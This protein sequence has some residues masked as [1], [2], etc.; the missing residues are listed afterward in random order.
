MSLLEATARARGIATG[1]V[2]QNTVEIADL[3]RA[4]IVRDG[5]KLPV[6]FSK[7]FFEGDLSQNIQL[8]PGD[9]IY[10]PG[11][12]SNQACIVGA[13]SSQGH[14]GVTE[15]LSALG[16][17]TIRGGFSPSAWKKKILIV[18]S[19]P[20]SKQPEI[21]T[22]DAAAILAGKQK[23]VLLK[24]RDIIYVHEKPWQRATEVLALAMRA[25]VQTGA[26]TWT[27]NNIGPILPD[28]SQPAR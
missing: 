2:E 10:F 14:V 28:P 12:S 6:D 16:A 3:R 1:L 19:Q 24:P 13:V 18:R 26:A 9:Y 15:G 4:F 27:G 22:I 7:L 11:S 25:F 20:D 23:D 17:I 21:I 5:K 8:Q